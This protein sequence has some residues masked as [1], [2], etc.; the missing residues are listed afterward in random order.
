M[1]YPYEEKHPQWQ[2]AFVFNT[3]RCI[4]CQTCTMACKSTWTFSKGQEYMWWNNVET[5]PFGGYPRHWDAKLLAMLEEANPGGQVWDS[6][7]FKGKTI[8]EAA[9]KRVGPEG[10]QTVMGYLPT[11][12]EWRAPNIHED[13]AA[14]GKWQ[15]GQ[16]NGSTQLP[17]HRVW[18]FYLARI[19]NHCTYPGCLGAC[20]RQAIYKRPEDGIVLVDQE[21]CRGY[22]KCV[23]G[24]PYKK[25]MYRGNTGTSEKCIGC[26]PRVEGSDELLCPVD[27]DTKQRAPIETRCMSACIGKIRLQGLVKIASDGKWE[28]DPKNPLYYL[29]R[30]RQVALPLYPQ[31]GTEPNG[32]YIPPRW[33]PRPYLRQMFGPG[34][35]HAIE[36]YSYP[37]RKLLAVLQLFRAQRQIIYRFEIEEGNEKITEVPVP[38]RKEPLKIYN[39]TVIGFNKFG[40][41]VVRVKI[42]EPIHRRPLE[43]HQNSI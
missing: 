5:K 27:E 8:F 10:P 2:F 12:A 32:Y 38:G 37:D 25:V 20:P 23:E 6:G 19:C 16:F 21:R 22:R 33:V 18:F 9:E 4:A 42:D 14:G 43:K 34:V 26:Y 13:H 15:P 7:V 30:E 29:I 17:E 36:Q 41:E 3:N 40:K 31:F 24:C 1:T 39:D 35:D 28:K 11:E